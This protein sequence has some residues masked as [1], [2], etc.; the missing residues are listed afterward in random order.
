[1]TDLTQIQI[2]EA[3]EADSEALTAIS[4]AAKR[5]WPYPEHYFDIWKSEL[6]ITSDYIN[7]NVVFKAQINGLILGFYS[8]VEN[9][10]DFYSGETLVRK[11]FYLEHI[12]ITPAFH[13]HGIGRLMIDHAKTLSKNR[14]IS[15]LL[16]FVDPY[17]K[18]F[19]DK[20]GAK[21]LYDSKSSIAGRLIPMYEL[22]VQ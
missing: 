11:G 12:F 7:Q 9:E 2:C 15:N 14:G 10:T 13:H 19:Y 8:M 17:A 20:V 18:G 3:V 1:M 6:T 22:K 21:Y 5:H 16:I 4:F